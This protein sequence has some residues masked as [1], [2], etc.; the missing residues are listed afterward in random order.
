MAVQ[1]GLQ[2]AGVEPLVLA[3][4]QVD[5]QRIGAGLDRHIVEPVVLVGWAGAAALLEVL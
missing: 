5:G 1:A 4:T 2:L 3:W